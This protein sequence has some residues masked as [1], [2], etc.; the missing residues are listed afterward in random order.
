MSSPK[1]KAFHIGV[2]AEA[3]AAAQFARCGVD[4]SVQYGPNQPEYDLV[5]S[6]K[7]KL[8]KVSVKGSQEGKWG[9]TQSFLEI[10]TA[11]YQGA[12]QRWL[13]KHDP[14]TIFCLVQ[15]KDVPLNELPRMYLAPPSEIAQRLGETANGRGETQLY[16]RHTWAANAV[17]AG[18]NEEIPKNWI[19]T[20]DRLNEMIDFAD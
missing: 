19:F 13:E 9:L 12:I 15:F 18:T 17:A 6:R 7:P 3:F 1:V 16:E 8:L 11:D 14:K 2:A 5:I 4:V 10:G 20:P